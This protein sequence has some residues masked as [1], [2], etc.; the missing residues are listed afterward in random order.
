MVEETNG[1]NQQ[2]CKVRRCC[3]H[4]A[5]PSVYGLSNRSGR[6]GQCAPG[7]ERQTQRSHNPAGLQIK[8]PSRFL[9]CSF[10]SPS[11]LA[12]AFA[13]SLNLFILVI[14][15]HVDTSKDTG[16]TYTHTHAHTR[17]QSSPPLLRYYF[18]RGLQVGASAH[19]LRTL[20]Q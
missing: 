5:H 7:F 15:G 10:L 1:Q 18:P 11:V 13:L 6:V 9:S 3:A 16:R 19:D 8:C 20:P 14:F 12:P 4:D 17:T 2:G